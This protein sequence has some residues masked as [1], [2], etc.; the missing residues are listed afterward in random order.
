MENPNLI[1]SMPP[2]EAN[3]LTNGTNRLVNDSS[4]YYKGLIGMILCIL[5]GAIIG[6]VFV[7][8]SLEQARDAITAYQNKPQMYTLS[9]FEMV[10]KGRMFARIGLAVFIAEIVALVAF[11]SMN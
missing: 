9:S 1:D 2:T 8:I 5:P 10:K 11:M 7:K 3:I 4:I 6:L